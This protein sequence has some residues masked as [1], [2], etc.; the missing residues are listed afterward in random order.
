MADADVVSC[1]LHAFVLSIFVADLIVGMEELELQT[2]SRYDFRNFKIA[3]ISV[4]ME[5][6]LLFLENGQ[7]QKLMNVSLL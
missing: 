4:K 5:Y 2:Q 7:K 1:C 3:T 6:I